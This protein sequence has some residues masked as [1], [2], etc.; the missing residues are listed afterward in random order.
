VVVRG[1]DGIVRG[2]RNACRHRG[3]QVAPMSR[4]SPTW[5]RSSTG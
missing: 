5:I 4:A 2:F 1:D 3:V